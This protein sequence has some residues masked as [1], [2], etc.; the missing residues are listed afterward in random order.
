MLFSKVVVCILG[1]FLFI[2][3]LCPEQSVWSY[4]LNLVVFLKVDTELFSFSLLVNVGLSCRGS[5][6]FYLSRADCDRN[7]DTL[8]KRPF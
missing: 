3:C 8:Y 2:F 1:Q 5:K 6:E 7:Y 4:P